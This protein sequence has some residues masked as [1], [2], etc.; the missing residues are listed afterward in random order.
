M[1]FF[2]YVTVMTAN[3]SELVTNWYQVFLETHVI[4]GS[5]TVEQQLLKIFFLR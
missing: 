2:I 3:T 1:I 5:V 4:D